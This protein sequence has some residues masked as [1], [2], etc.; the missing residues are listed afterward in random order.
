MAYENS[1]SE[2]LVRAREAREITGHG[3]SSFWQAVADHDLP[4]PVRIGKRSVAWKLS[5]LQAWVSSRPSARREDRVRL[6]GA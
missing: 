6:E 1:S 3:R 5:E 2:R 4:A